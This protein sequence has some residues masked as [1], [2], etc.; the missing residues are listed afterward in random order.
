M[1]KILTVVETL[2]QQMAATTTMSHDL[3]SVQGIFPLRTLEDFNSLKEKVSRDDEFR[4]ALV[5]S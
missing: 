3:T 5:G 2:Q 4:K 1:E